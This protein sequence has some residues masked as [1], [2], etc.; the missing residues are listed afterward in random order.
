MEVTLS[1][2]TNKQ[3]IRILKSC[4][5]SDLLQKQYYLQQINVKIPSND[6]ILVRI[7]E[8]DN[9]ILTKEELEQPIETYLSV[10]NQP[11]EFRIA[12]LI[13]II[14]YDDNQIFSIPISNR[15][16][17][18]EQLIQMTPIKDEMYK[19][20]ASYNT[21]MIISN[22]EQLLN[23]METKFHLVKDTETCFILIDLSENSLVKNN[24]EKIEYQ[25]YTIFAT[26]A[27]LYQQNKELIK[28]QYLLFDN[29]IILSP[30]T[31]LTCFLP[32]KSSIRFTLI[33]KILQANITITNDEQQDLSIKFQCSPSIEV[34]RLTQLAC[35]LFNVNRRFYRLIDFDDA[36]VDESMLLYE[37]TESVNDVQFKLIS[38]ADVKCLIKYEDKI[39]LIS[40]Y[41]TTLASTIFEEALEKLLIPKE[42]INMYLLHI[43]DDQEDP[44]DIDLTMSMEDILEISSIESTIISLQL[45]KKQ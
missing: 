18:I 24:E 31:P 13:Q 14:K 1:Y 43:M 3:N 35:Q 23:L 32:I 28:D 2:E 37:L 5:V 10:D 41:R 30:E 29:V 16:I 17:T 9:E 11:I 36:E 8:P 6:C 33:N 39:T 12:I 27:D 45:T 26:I 19:Y 25:R 21:H 4:P 40:A 15:N 7:K 42:N 22:S 44:T 34:D 38:I 20:L